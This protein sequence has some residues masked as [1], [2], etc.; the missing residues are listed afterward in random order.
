MCHKVSVLMAV[1]VLVAEMVVMV[2]V[3]NNKMRRN[4]TIEKALFLESTC[5]SIQLKPQL[6]SATGITP[7]RSL[8]KCM[9][10]ISCQS[11]SA[12]IHYYAPPPLHLCPRNEIKS[13]YLL[14]GID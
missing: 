14:Y 5:F 6:T 1:A 8:Q 2:T 13:F 4:F 9:A 3:K 11:E 10:M 12:Q 7:E